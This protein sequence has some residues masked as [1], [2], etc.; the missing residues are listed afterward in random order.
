MMG[1]VVSGP[2]LSGKDQVPSPKDNC[3]NRALNP[4]LYEYL[5]SQLHRGC[6]WLRLTALSPDLMD[7]M[8]RGD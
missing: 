4:W 2:A 5:A 6:H 8:M 3:R 7:N 1:T